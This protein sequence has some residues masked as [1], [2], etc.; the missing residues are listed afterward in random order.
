[1]NSFSSEACNSVIS[2]PKSLQI[3]CCPFKA[4]EILSLFSYSLTHYLNLSHFNGP[5]LLV[6]L[7]V[8]L[9]HYLSTHSCFLPQTLNVSQRNSPV[10]S[11]CHPLYFPFLQTPPRIIIALT[12]EGQSK[13]HIP[14]REPVGRCM[15]GH[16]VLFQSP[17]CPWLTVQWDKEDSAG[18]SNICPPRN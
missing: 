12:L 8:S 2:A 16:P 17:V 11:F 5:L 10:L 15:S 7:C 13:C 18:Q 1:M 3:H 14:V 9:P 6:P 4:L